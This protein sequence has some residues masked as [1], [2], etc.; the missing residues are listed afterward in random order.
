V[1]NIRDRAIVAGQLWD[2]G[3]LNVAFHPTRARAS[4]IDGVV[5]QDRHILI[6]EGKPHPYAWEEGSA[7]YRTLK[8]L[9]GKPGVCVLVLYGDPAGP[10]VRQAEQ[11]IPMGPRH[12]P[13]VP[14]S[15]DDVI[16]WVAEWFG[17]THLC[18]EPFSCL[19]TEPIELSAHLGDGTA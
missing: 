10:H 1:F 7:Q 6:L 8:T 13:R 5:E 15:N 3:W 16:R 2:W 11:V 9:S 12:L 4:D 14:A 19:Y 18:R 17:H